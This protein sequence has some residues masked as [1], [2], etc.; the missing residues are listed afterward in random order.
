MLTF[1]V[2]S[3]TRIKGR[4]QKDCLPGPQVHFMDTVVDFGYLVDIIA[5]SISL[6]FAAFPRKLPEPTAKASDWQS[7]LCSERVQ[8]R[9]ERGWSWA[10]CPTS[11]AGYRWPVVFEIN[12]GRRLLF[13]RK[14]SEDAPENMPE[15]MTEGAP[16]R[17]PAGKTDRRCA[18]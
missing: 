12:R 8:E 18:R 17:M 5:Y 13:T 15:R 7:L 4:K 11:E 10:E 16:D 14:M 9:L 2:N 6:R 3:I 1:F